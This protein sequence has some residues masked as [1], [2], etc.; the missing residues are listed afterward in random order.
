MAV[1]V[2]KELSGGVTCITGSAKNT[3]KTTFM[4]HVLPI[5]RREGTTAYLTIGVDGER[6][7]RIFGTP[8]PLIRAGEGD[9]LVTSETMAAAGDLLYSL[10]EVFPF[11][12]VL[13]RI[14]LLKV[15]RG[16][17]VELAGPADN[18]QLSCILNYLQRETPAD[19][20]IIDGAVNRIT[21]VSS[22]GQAGFVYVLEVSPES[23]DGALKIMKKLVLTQGLEPPG[24]EEDCFSLEG[25]LTAAKA[26]TVPREAGCLSVEDFTKIFLDERELR[27]LMKRVTLRCRN[28]YSLRFFVVNL[29]DM[30][31]EDFLDVLEAHGLDEK[32]LFNPYQRE[33][34]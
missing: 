1:D 2:G 13:G 31:R 19:S 5:L 12:T 33:V 3:G 26:G 18:R 20:V 30:R 14:V 16:G 15:L 10:E 32:I 17:T 9:Y 7:D 29:K 27:T 28:T 8:K 6:R 23:L 11:R 4:N 21:Q 25:A 24:E 34:I 22:A